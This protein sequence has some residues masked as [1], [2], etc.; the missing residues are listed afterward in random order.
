LYRT[1]IFKLCFYVDLIS[2]F[3]LVVLFVVTLMF[4]V[5]QMT[6]IWAHVYHRWSPVGSIY[7][8]SKTTT[9]KMIKWL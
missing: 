1:Y 8:E 6:T 5:Q 3:V 4:T 2:S 7:W 9:G